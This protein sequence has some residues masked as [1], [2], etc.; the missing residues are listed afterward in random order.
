M[1][2][3]VT[4]RRE[5]SVPEH[6]SELTPGQYE[7]YC[8]LFLAL[9]S[10]MIDMDYYRVRWF[11]F[12]LGRGKSDFTILRDEHVAE[13]KAQMSAI[14]GFFVDDGAG[15]VRP[16]FGCVANLLPEYG[17]F[18]GPGDILQGV[19]LGEFVECCTVA[20]CLDSGD[21]DALSE[22]YA[23]I[24]R[25]LYHVPEEVEVPDILRFHAPNLFF[26]VLRY[27]NREPV[28]IN[29]KKLDLRILFRKSAAS[30]PDDGTGWTGIIFEIA[31][32]GLFGDAVGVRR[33]DL[34]E[35]LLYLYKCKFEYL[36]DKSTNN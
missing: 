12:L 9:S 18:R 19:T 35:V 15:D 17:G 7:Y 6:V 31:E 1:R 25:V 13:L 27:L 11:S 36:H 8:R 33:T 10:G 21:A 4:R 26:N 32:A 16:D 28:E 5:V 14:G 3:V 34:W 30:K 20:D 2:T 22:G 23:H 24:A 29:G